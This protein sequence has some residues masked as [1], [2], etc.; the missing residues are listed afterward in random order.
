VQG[1]IVAVLIVV[2][3]AL[4]ALTRAVYSLQAEAQEGIR[5]I[6]ALLDQLETDVTDEDTVIDSC[7]T[8][9]TEL[10]ALITAAG[11]DPVR[12]QALVT[13]I[14]AKKAALAA[15]VVANTPAAPTT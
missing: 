8:L 13:T 1:V 15:A 14:E 12:L 4:I 5:K 9:L 3:L 2:A 6:M 7:I 11:T 10:T